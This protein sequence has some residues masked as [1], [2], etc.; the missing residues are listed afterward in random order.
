MWTDTVTP[1]R[2]WADTHDLWW[3]MLQRPRTDTR[4]LYHPRPRAGNKGSCTQEP[5]AEES[6]LAEDGYEYNDWDDSSFTRQ[7]YSAEELD[8]WE[9]EGDLETFLSGESDWIHRDMFDSD[10]LT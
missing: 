1:E 6:F 4:R 10:T 7:Q 3:D 9:E 2:L 8:V 5:W